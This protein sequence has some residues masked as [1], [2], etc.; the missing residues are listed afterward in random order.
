MQ[1]NTAW[2]DNI[3]AS[4]ERI[5]S[6]ES[7]DELANDDFF[8]LVRENPEIDTRVDHTCF[9]ANHQQFPI[10]ASMFLRDL[11]LVRRIYSVDVM[12]SL[13]R[14]FGFLEG[15]LSYAQGRQ[16]CPE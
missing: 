6:Q 11:F 9:A 12:Q 10:N 3:R 15:C 14:Y 5:N 7:E 13:A 8:T 1:D 16:A 2:K 4:L